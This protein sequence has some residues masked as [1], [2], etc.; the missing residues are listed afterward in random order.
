[1]SI[2]FQGFGLIQKEV[3]D[4]SVYM[5]IVMQLLVMLLR[6]V[7][8]NLPFIDIISYVKLPF[9]ALVVVVVTPSLLR[10]WSLSANSQKKFALICISTLFSCLLST[11]LNDVSARL[12]YVLYFVEW[13]FL[14]GS[15]VLIAVKPKYVRLF[16]VGYLAM[17]SITVIVGMVEGVNSL[18]NYA[19]VDSL[20]DGRFKGVGFDPNYFAMSI[21]IPFAYVLA[22]GSCWRN[23]GK[24]RFFYLIIASFFVISLM[25]SRSR[26]GMMSLALIVFVVV[27]VRGVRTSLNMFMYMLISLVCT[28]SIIGFNNVQNIY[29]DMMMRWVLEYQAG[30]TG[31]VDLWVASINNIMYKPVW[32]WGPGSLPFLLSSGIYQGMYGYIKPHNAW[33]VGAIERGLLGITL[34]ISLLLLG[35]KYSWK[36][37]RT[38]DLS[39]QSL[40]VALLAGLAGQGLMTLTL[41][42]MPYGIFIVSSFSVGLYFYSNKGLN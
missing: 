17:I 20:E 22:E 33:I 11:L 3:D 23:S 40:G 10:S 28:V 29:S 41:G 39:L 13:T 2:A 8:F 37:C 38:Q 25:W 9:A 14:V 19:V 35:M 34:Q 21:M 24:K 6:E 7:T 26:S 16:F 15:S 27:Y 12:A 36:L 32:G 42:G 5:I 18:Y 1:M 31:R 30:G 4:R